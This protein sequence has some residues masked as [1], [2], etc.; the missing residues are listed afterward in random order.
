MYDCVGGAHMTPG[1]YSTFASNRNGT[2]IDAI[3]LNGSY[4]NFPPGIYF[5]S[6]F[7]ISVWVYPI[8]CQSY[9]KI[10]DFGTGQ[11]TYNIILG[12][13]TNSVYQLDVYFYTNGYIKVYLSPYTLSSYIW[14]FITVTF[15]SRTTIIYVNGKSVG[16]MTISYW[17]PEN[18]TRNQSYCGK[19]NWNGDGYS[20]S[21]VDQFQ[22]YNRALSQS[23][24]TYLMSLDD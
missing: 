17:V 11:D 5:N 21:Y 2:S 16:S 10:A 6:A 18:V 24:I 1:P 15:D 8:K 23:E 22:I 14:Y 4:T 20:S 12:F 3:N 19:S 13:S 7:T 9:A